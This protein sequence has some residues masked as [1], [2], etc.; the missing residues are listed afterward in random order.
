MKNALGT[1]VDITVINDGELCGCQI[2]EPHASDVRASMFNVMSVYVCVC[3]AQQQRGVDSTILT[4][5]KI[6]MMNN[7]MM[8]DNV[9]H[10][11]IEATVPQYPRPMKWAST[12]Y[13][14]W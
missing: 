14:N 4:I 8:F 9:L 10:T 11:N 1:K 13:V 3:T 12:S 2:A 7:Y 6:L 5:Y